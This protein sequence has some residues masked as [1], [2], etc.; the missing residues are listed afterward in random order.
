MGQLGQSA[1]RELELTTR[2]EAKFNR[3]FLQDNDGESVTLIPTWLHG[4]MDRKWTSGYD[5]P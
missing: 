1:K 5:L 2:L 3:S 4:D